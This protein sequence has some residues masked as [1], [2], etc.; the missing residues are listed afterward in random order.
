M[1][2]F[3]IATISSFLVDAYFLWHY[4][5]RGGLVVCPSLSDQFI[6]VDRRLRIA[7]G[8]GPWTDSFHILHSR[9]AAADKAPP[10]HATR[11]R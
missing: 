2:D 10:A 5:R 11:I 8:I 7:T 3:D 4:V 9:V 6:A 1:F